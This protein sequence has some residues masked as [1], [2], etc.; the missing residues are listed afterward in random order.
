M[1][2][3]LIVNPYTEILFEDR[4]SRPWF[5]TQSD[6]DFFLVSPMPR[7]G[8]NLLGISKARHPKLYE[9]F[10]DLAKSK[11]DFLDI[12]N[13]L[14]GPE[15]IFL[16]ENGVLVEEEKAPEKPLFHC[17]LDEVETNGFN[18]ESADLLVNPTFHFEPFSFEN[19]RNWI[20]HKHLS[21]YQPSVW[22][23]QPLTE[24]ESGY[25]LDN[26]QA[27]IVSKF[28]A[29]EKPTFEIE[30]D[31]ISKLVA[32][33]ILVFPG[34]FQKKEKTVI[35]SVKRAKREFQQLN[36]TVLRE[37]I[38]PPQMK[39]MRRF[40]RELIDQGFMIFGDP[41]V[42][43]RFKRP[44]EPLA[45]VFH[46]NLTHLMSILA[47]KEVKPSYVFAASY[48]EFAELLPHTDRK[49]CEFSI[50]FQVDYQPEP[51]NHLSPWALYISQPDFPIDF[52]RPYHG[53]NF[54]AK[55][56]EVDKNKPIHL[57]S[58]DA[59]F[60]KGCEVIHYRYALPANHQSTS[61]FFHY[62][63]KNFEDDLLL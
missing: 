10:L 13:D 46:E 18:G 63:P 60:Y 31:L 48:R 44:N 24:I 58:G 53:E 7:K 25:W 43:R 26:A 45:R 11:F 28:R 41:Q 22:V 9:L 35:E 8:L 38:K 50:S 19:L 15:R 42:G 17:L 29:G 2:C 39:A 55:C 52:E 6:V 57:A 32:A 23:R 3:K 49:Q 37:L 56:P 16:T 61:L 1:K 59:V 47:G 51:E 4:Y 36:Y 33:E 62:V 27:E 5:D 21:P 54:P 40:Y 30:N 14:D 34:T 20:I 12:E